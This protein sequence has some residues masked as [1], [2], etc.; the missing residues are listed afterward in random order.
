MSISVRDC[1]ARAAGNHQL[2]KLQNHFTLAGHRRR[3]AKSRTGTMMKPSLT[4]SLTALI[5][6]LMLPAPGA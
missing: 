2:G 5:A 1:A 6:S 4:A 3:K